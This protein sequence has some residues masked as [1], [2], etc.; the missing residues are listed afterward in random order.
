[1]KIGM[2]L[3]ANYPEDIRVTKEATSLI[4][5][6]HE[7][8]LLCRKANR[9]EASSEMVDGIHIKRIYVGSHLYIT[10]FWSTFI[11]AFWIH[12][13]FS[14]AIPKFIKTYN[15]E[16]LH[17]HDLPLAY[18]AIRRSKKFNL[19]IILDL[20]EN[21][22]AGVKEWFVLKKNPIVKLKNHLFFGYKK[23]SKY[24]KRMCMQVDHIITVVE[25]MKE[26]IIKVTHVNPDKI[27]VIHN[28]E[29]T[30]FY[31]ER[32]PH[33]KIINQNSSK[34]V[35]TYI[36]G[37]GPHRGLET[38]LKA[39]NELRRKI[40]EIKL[41][42]VG[43]GTILN[44]LKTLT[45]EHQIQDI[46]EFKGQ[47]PFNEVF[48]HMLASNI[49]IIPH[50]S[51]EQNEAGMPHK[52]FQCLQIGKPLLVSDCKPLKRI[53]ESVDG[54]YV[55]LSGDVK[56]FQSKVLHIYTNPNEAMAKAKNA[57]YH[58]LNGKLNWET[59]SKSLISMYKKILSDTGSKLLWN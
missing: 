52:F 3:D 5:A 45:I 2:V 59:T 12:P 15:L 9:Y 26:R 19:R 14:I 54:G 49:N 40:P 18:T 41:V 50:K 47:R 55:F 13:L 46:V 51:G 31:Y 16:I 1:M 8:F 10:T 20:H 44:T 27:E 30:S 25:E 6:G 11:G 4:K 39:M 43:T 22:P 35:I 38:P 33:P 29:P 56:D 7:V 36:G 32:E 57:Q 23:W 34:F 48:S 17:V 42:L 58:A 21:Y 53:I 24:E 28:S 37:L